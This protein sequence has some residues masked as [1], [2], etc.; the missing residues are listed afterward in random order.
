MVLKLN[1][2]LCGG[3]GGAAA[4]APHNLTRAKDKSLGKIGFAIAI[5]RLLSFSRASFSHFNDNFRMETH[6]HTFA[7]RDDSADDSVHPVSFPLHRTHNGT[8]ALDEILITVVAIAQTHG[9]N[10]DEDAT[11]I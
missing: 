7:S 5:E 3:C 1:C 6:T 9:D 10:D 4:M 8:R 11:F 2:I